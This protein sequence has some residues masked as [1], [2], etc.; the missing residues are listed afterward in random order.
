LSLSIV[1]SG[2]HQPLEDPVAEELTER[3]RRGGVVRRSP[4]SGEVIERSPMAEL[5]E[6]LHAASE[7]S[8]AY[9]PT[10]PEQGVLF[11]VLDF[12]LQDVKVSRFPESAMDLRYALFADMDDRR[13]QRDT[14]FV[15]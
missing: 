9:V 3:L 7:A 12:W 10:E 14:G 5:A 1:A 4:E 13:R 6:R 8:E 11:A 15:L 2:I